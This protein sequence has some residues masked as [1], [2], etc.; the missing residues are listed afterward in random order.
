MMTTTTTTMIGTTQTQ[1]DSPREEDERSFERSLFAI[2]DRTPAYDQQTTSKHDDDLLL[3]VWLTTQ[4]DLPPVPV[5]RPSVRRPCLL[6]EKTQSK[7]V[8]ALPFVSLPSLSPPFS[9]PLTQCTHSCLALPPPFFFVL[10]VKAGD[11]SGYKGRG[12]FAAERKK[13]GPESHS[14][15]KETTALSQIG[16]MTC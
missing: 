6:L 14:T 15:R 1:N 8:V 9:L 16:L 11:Y 5:R 12:Q 13:D 4:R 10:A 3:I 7:R 2:E